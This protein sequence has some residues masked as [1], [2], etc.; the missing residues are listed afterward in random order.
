MDKDAGHQNRAHTKKNLHKFIK[1]DETKKLQSIHILAIHK[2]LSTHKFK[3]TT[4]KKK[5]IINRKTIC[6]N[7]YI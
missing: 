4:T 2:M 5:S 3:K 1:D 6:V 7:D